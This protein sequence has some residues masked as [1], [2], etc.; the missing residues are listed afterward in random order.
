[1]VFFKISFLFLLLFYVCC[2]PCVWDM[3]VCALC[4]RTHTV[5]VAVRREHRRAPSW[6]LGMHPGSEQEQP[7]QS[8]SE[9]QLGP[10]R[11]MVL[12]DKMG[13]QRGAVRR[14]CSHY[15]IEETL[16]L[17]QLHLS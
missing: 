3:H 5:P 10:Q 2:A 14:V 12:R 1:M 9:V 6:V 17:Q 11:T 13:A 4:A 7:V 15:H 8:I 16:N